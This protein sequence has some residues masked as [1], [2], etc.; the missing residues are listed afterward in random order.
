MRIFQKIE[1]LSR[2]EFHARLLWGM[3]QPWEPQRYQS[4]KWLMLDRPVSEILTQNDSNWNGPAVRNG[5]LAM[6]SWMLAIEIIGLSVLPLAATL[7]R[8]SPD[9]GAFSARLL[10]IV[11]VGWLVWIGASVGFWT[12]SIWSTFIILAALAALSWGFWLSKPLSI[13]RSMLPSRASYL[14]GAAI[15]GGLFV[16]FL[17]FR[18]LYP[19]FWQ[20]YYGGEKPFELAYLRAVAN[21]AEFPAYD[22]W[23]AGGFINYYYYGWHLVASVTKL[24]GVGVSMGFQ[25]AAAML[26]ALV[27]LQCF[28]VTG[29]LARYGRRG[30]LVGAIPITGFLTAF[31]VLVAGNLDGVRQLAEHGTQAADRFDFWRSTRV[32]DFTIN[33]F[34]YFSQIWADVHPHVI[35]LPICVL[36]LTLLSHLVVHVRREIAGERPESVLQPLYLFTIA[37]VLGTI[38]VT[39]SWDAPLAAGLTIGAYVYAGA[40]RGGWNIATGLGAGLLVAIAA[41]ALFAPFYSHFYSVV[42]G[43]ATTTE[44]S[45]VGQFMTHWGIFILIVVAVTISAALRNR[46]SRHGANSG[47][48]TGAVCFAG[49]GTTALVLAVQESPPAL[50]PFITTLLVATAFIVIGAVVA[51]PTRLSPWLMALTIAFAA[52]TGFLAP[53]RPAAS[54]VAAIATVAVMFALRRWRHPQTFVPW[55][56]I[57]IACVTIAAVELLYVADDLRNSPWERMNSVFKF[58][59]QAW[60]LFGI[61]AAVLLGRVIRGASSTSRSRSARFLTMGILGFALIAGII[62]PVFGTPARLSQDMESSPLSLTLDGYSWMEGGSIQNATGDT[63]SFGGDLAAIEWLNMNT[64]GTP[65]LLEAAIGPYRGNGSRISSATGLPAVL[66]WDRH[67]SQQRY[68]QGISHRMQDVEAIYNSTDPDAKL[69]ALRRYDVRY[70]IVGDVERYWNS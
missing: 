48:L 4:D 27:G 49:G 57:A 68:E 42:D 44:G 69:E 59:L 6:L 65:V 13:R 29:L 26:A 47:M 34:P 21:S 31:L 50:V 36:L 41:L 19:D 52:A 53:V 9:R 22:P 24:S 63:I 61:G 11:I 40:L 10:G 30:W 5:L 64:S 56:L 66:G 1:N 28:A 15:Y 60:M 38:F 37:L 70:V 67:Q 62:Y 39:N 8:R 20:T 32:V 45:S 2:D 3:D 55:A 12:A 18:A 16:L 33:E 14:G 17:T 58:Y 25:L 7:L 35:N 51:R 43:V 54:L 23:Y 46:L